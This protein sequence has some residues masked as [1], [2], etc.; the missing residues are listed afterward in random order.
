MA[1]NGLPFSLVIGGTSVSFKENAV[2]D[3]APPINST[4]KTLRD[5]SE[6]VGYTTRERNIVDLAIDFRGHVQPTG[7]TWPSIA[8][9]VNIVD[10]S[11]SYNGVL[12]YSGDALYVEEFGYSGQA[13]GEG[14]LSIKAYADGAYNANV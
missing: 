7:G 5:G 2:T 9:G 14:F 11:Y 10:W 1:V 6:N 12:L 4:T 3:K 8:K 13:E